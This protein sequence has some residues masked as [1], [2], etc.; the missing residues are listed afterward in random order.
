M[1]VM[2]HKEDGVK[3]L[4]IDEFPIMDEEAIEEF[5]IRKI[6]KRR[7]QREESFRRLERE[8]QLYESAD[9]VLSI[10]NAKMKEVFA[11]KTV[12][13]VLAQLDTPEQRLWR[14]RESEESIQL[15]LRG[16]QLAEEQAL[17]Q[18]SLRELFEVTTGQLPASDFQKYRAKTLMDAAMA[19]LPR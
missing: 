3:A 7:T 4:A 15:R 2:L 17:A 1:I 9:P 8:A 13:D 6:E 19:A 16:P 18:Y 12:G 14:Q 10:N 5:Y 11:G